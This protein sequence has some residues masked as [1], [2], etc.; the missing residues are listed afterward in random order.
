MTATSRH[1]TEGELNLA[2]DLACR[3]FDAM[4]GSPTDLRFGAV[5][6]LVASMFSV[7]VKPESR[8]QAFDDFCEVVRNSV[9]GSLT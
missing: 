7:L 6:L 9:R 2:Q 8:L 3:L 4:D 5:S 1:P